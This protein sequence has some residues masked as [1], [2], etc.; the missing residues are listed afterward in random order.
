MRNPLPVQELQEILGTNGF[1]HLYG[2]DQVLFVSDAPRRISQEALAR[3]RRTM[4]A[5]GFTAQISPSNLLLIDLQPG[6][7]ERL[8]CSFPH[9]EAVSVPADDR[10]LDVYALARLLMRHP[11]ALENQPME[12]I[13]A[14][15]KRYA[16][17][18]GLPVLTPLLLSQCAQKIR[19]RE[20][21]PSALADILVFW[22]T[23]QKKEAR[24]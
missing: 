11:S 17:K 12:M 10:W 22:L 8:L 1:L 16:R 9:A 5:Q 2:Q 4:T 6:R 15:F 23:E 21:L 20:P 7:W 13:R 24:I 14:V 19:C 3:I 18:D